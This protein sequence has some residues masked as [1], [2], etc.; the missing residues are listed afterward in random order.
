[1]RNKL[2]KSA[3]TALTQCLNVKPNESVLIVTNPEKMS[4]SDA[5]YTEAIKLKAE[6]SII[7]YPA[8][9][10]NGEEPPKIVEE[11]MMNADVVLAPT[12]VSISHTEA[13]RR[14]SSERKARIATLPGIT[15][16]IFVRGLGADYTEISKISKRVQR[17]LTKAKK[18]YVTSPSGT[19]IEIDTDNP[20]LISDG[21]IKKRGAFSNL[22]D[23]ET[24]LAPTNANGTIVI[25]RCGDVISKPTKIEIKNGY[26]IRYENSPSGKR[27]KKMIENAKKID[28]NNNA[29]YI[30]EFAIGTNPSAKVTGVIL[31]DEKALGTCHIAFGDNMSFLGG[32]NKSIIHLDIIVLK[33]TIKLDKKIIMKKGKLLV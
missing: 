14:A 23:G 17:Y 3:R 32:K 26:I 10:I 33:P 8:G 20:A 15:E 27:F 19:N 24:E 16:E 28:K 13:R 6:P 4:I 21:N 12:V 22:P 1:M 25:D 7:I 30:A 29:C 31:E 11:A 9:K 5:I 2:L 18:A